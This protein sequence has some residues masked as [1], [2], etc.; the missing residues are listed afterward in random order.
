MKD[1]RSS[2]ELVHVLRHSFRPS[3]KLQTSLEKFTKQGLTRPRFLIKTL[4]AIAL[5]TLDVSN[6]YHDV[7]I[8]GAIEKFEQYRDPIQIGYP[9]AAQR[10]AD[11][12]LKI[13]LSSQNHKDIVD[14]T[15]KTHDKLPSGVLL[16]DNEDDRFD[17]FVHIDASHA[18]SQD[19]II[20]PGLQLRDELR[21]D[22]AYLYKMTTN[23]IA[24]RDELRVM[25][26]PP[27]EEAS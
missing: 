23:S 8:K 20:T 18:L 9:L 26:I 21:G 10:M 2:T 15:S 13:F 25:P 17:L 12:A 7:A 22:R 3:E 16:D 24:G 1:A 14:L 27:Y 5:N 4:S 19:R 11:G 6:S